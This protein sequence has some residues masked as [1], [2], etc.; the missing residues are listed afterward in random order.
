MENYHHPKTVVVVPVVRVVVVAGG[1]TGIVQRVVERAA[2]QGGSSGLDLT[3]LS[4]TFPT[5]F[6]LRWSCG[7]RAHIGRC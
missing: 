4:A 3:I 5:N 6:P 7:T 1:H 2:P